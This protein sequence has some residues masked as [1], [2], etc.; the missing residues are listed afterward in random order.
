MHCIGIL[1]YI[2]IFGYVSD[3]RHLADNL[4]VIECKGRI[5]R[6]AKE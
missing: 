2:F 1:V 6:I 5:D 4:R 3:F